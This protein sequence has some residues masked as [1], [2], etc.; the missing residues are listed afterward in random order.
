MVKTEGLGLALR[1]PIGP[2]R[3]EH[4][5]GAGDIGFDKGP[6][7]VDRA[8]HMAFGGQMHHRIGLM[9]RKCRIQ[10]RTVADIGMD[11]GIVRAL[12]RLGH[13]VQTGR[14]GQRIEVDHLMPAR[15]RQT[16]HGRSDKTG[17][18]GDEQ[19]HAPPSHV[20]GLSNAANPCAVASLSESRASA[21]SGIGQSMPQLSQCTAPSHSGA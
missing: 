5:I 6:R 8:T 21:P 16:H 9:R 20:K 18:A 11:K 4:I 15:N 2:R 12:R 10:R 14:I 7:P 17:P 13:I 19:L 1:R 3:L